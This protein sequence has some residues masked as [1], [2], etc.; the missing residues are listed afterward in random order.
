MAT[1]AGYSQAVLANSPAAYWR[2]GESSGTNAAD[3]SGNG[4]TGT[5]QGGST[6]GAGGLVGDGTAAVSLDGVDDRVLANDTASLSPTSAVTVEAWVR[7]TSFASTPRDYRTIVIKANSY[8]LRVDN[9]GGIQRPHF[10]IRD[11]GNYYA[12]TGNV[13][14]STGTTYHLVGTYDGTTIRIYVNGIAQGSN[15]HTGP[16][17]DSTIPLVIGGNWNGVVDEVAVYRSALSGSAVQQHYT[18]GTTSAPAFTVSSSIANGST[19]SG[20]VT[21]QAT[22]SASASKVEFY[23]D[24]V[25][26]WTEYA[27]PYVFNG[28]GA[29][30]DTR[31]L[32]NG[33]H[34]LKVVA[35]ATT[36]ATASQTANVTVANNAPPPP[37]GGSAGHVQYVAPKA[38]NSMAT[39]INN[40]T[41][42]QQ[43]WMRDHWQRAIVD[44]EGYWDSKL[45][46]YS[47]AWAYKNSYAI[48]TS[49]SVASQHPDWILKDSSGKKLYIPFGC[50]GGSCPAYAA[51]IGNSAWRQY[52]IDMCKAL[53]AKGYKGI[54]VDDVD[55]DI[56]TSNGSGTKVTPIDPRT[57]AAMT[58][59]A[60][61]NYFATFM[62][63][64]RSAIPNAEITHNAVWFAGGGQHDGTQPDIVREIKASSYVNLERGFVDS[65]LTGGTGT[66]SVFAFMRY[67]DNVHAYGRHVVLL[68]SA[69]DTANAEYNLAGYFLIS[70]GR[71]YVSSNLGKLPTNAWSG[72]S[73]DLGDAK[74]ARYQ[75]NGVWRRDF[76]RGFV[77]LN[78]PGA[79]TKTLSLGG[80]YKNTAGQTVT[81]VTLGAA[82]GAVLSTP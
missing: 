46:W 26:K 31:T 54:F 42:A 9:E 34:A 4:N 37:P 8:W 23:I 21:W 76:T 67:I 12:A 65:G 1:G 60:W 30:L 13:A 61:K 25:L 64:L 14:L 27:G 16:I 28:D 79:S 45:S 75:W 69:N 29:Q 80:S 47:N 7:A 22:P 62:E 11:S 33:S 20:S 17:V 44:G 2:L 78:E 5:Y 10:Y 39:W 24:N 48:Y 32:S 59:A 51:D 50:S 82:R 63:Q 15:A 49:S 19:L 52:Y 36:G 43:Q 18:A 77:L 71:D 41:P 81:S 3:S 55:M 53:V 38:D 74:G 56:N 6:L 68:S 58:D 40:A 72:Y 57:G 35:T 70:D 66:W 73:V